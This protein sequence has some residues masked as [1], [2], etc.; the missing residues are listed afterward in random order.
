MS[1]LRSLMRKNLAF[2][3]CTENVELEEK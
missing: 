2:D 3:I 1:F